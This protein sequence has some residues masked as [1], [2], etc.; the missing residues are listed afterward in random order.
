MLGAP[1]AGKGTQAKR[2][3]RKYRLVHIS[4]GEIFRDHVR[5]NTAIGAKIQSALELGQLMSDALTCE[6]LWRRLE[7]PDCADGF[8]IDGFPRSLAQADALQVWLA[9]RDESLDAAIELAVPDSEIIERTCARRS[10]S[11]CGAIYN[12][13]FDPPARMPYCDRP[14]CTGQLVQRDDDTEVTLAERLRI[15]RRVSSLVHEFYDGLGLLRPIDAAHLSPD[16]LFQKIEEVVLSLG[17][18]EPA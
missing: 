10:C 16:A 3:A 6:V 8:V 7:E 15:F 14:G 18:S 12:L 13:K 9:A 4:T 11:A 5:R 17:A 1:G 2:I